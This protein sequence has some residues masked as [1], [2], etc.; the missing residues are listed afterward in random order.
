MAGMSRLQTEAAVMMPAANPPS[1]LTVRRPMLLRKKKTQ[2]A[3][4]AVPK[5]GIKI[6]KA[7]SIINKFQP[8]HGAK[9]KRPIISIGAA[10]GIC[11]ELSMGEGTCGR[12]ALRR[13]GAL[14]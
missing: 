13:G 9:R 12:G 14:F 3:P 5:K 4:S 8:F 10:C 11:S 7:I 2:A 6:P 1:A